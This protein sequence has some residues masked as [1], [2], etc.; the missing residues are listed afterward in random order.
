MKPESS[1]GKNTTERMVRRS[2]SKDRASKQLSISN[3]FKPQVKPEGRVATELAALSSVANLKLDLAQTKIKSDYLQKLEEGLEDFDNESQI[4]QKLEP[5]K[6][7]LIGAGL[8]IMQDERKRIGNPSTENFSQ[9]D[10]AP[11]P[12]V[13]KPVKPKSTGL[14]Q[15]HVGK[16]SSRD[17]LKKEGNWAGF[18][19]LPNPKLL[20]NPPEVKN[21]SILEIK[22]EESPAS[23]LISEKSNQ[24]NLAS[25]IQELGHRKMKREMSRFISG[26]DLGQSQIFSKVAESEKNPVQSEINTKGLYGGFGDSDR[27]KKVSSHFGNLQ[28]LSNFSQQKASRILGKKVELENQKMEKRVPKNSVTNKQ[29]K[30]ESQTENLKK[31]ETAQNQLNPTQIFSKRI[32]QKESSNTDNNHNKKDLASQQNRV[33]SIVQRYGGSA[34]NTLRKGSYDNVKDIQFS[35]FKDQSQAN[36]V[37]S[38]LSKINREQIADLN[39]N[40]Q[41]EQILNSE[42][43]LQN[44]GKLEDAQQNSNL[45]QLQQKNISIQKMNKTENPKLSGNKDPNNPNQQSNS[46]KTEI[47][48]ASKI[49]NELKKRKRILKSRH[50]QRRRRAGPKQQGRQKRKNRESKDKRS[51]IKMMSYQEV[52]RYGLEIPYLNWGSIDPWYKDKMEGKIF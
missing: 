40:L 37:I 24:R 25:E 14:Q 21:L 23:L 31:I 5:P 8:G 1:P 10:S 28:K 32:E 47:L 42:H 46:K 49:R 48:T 38:G 17:H 3:Y 15:N 9:T 27:Y 2:G 12:K 30:I 39:K 43:N 41:R 34:V 36:E 33:E 7:N 19:P 26:I 52:T 22:N 20:Q 13:R 35:G 45:K 4:A 18:R 11:F 29:H 16:K 51:K 6:R 50:A 44:L